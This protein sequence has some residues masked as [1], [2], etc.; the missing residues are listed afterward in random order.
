MQTLVI[1]ATKHEIEL[2]SAENKTADILITGV[3]VPATCYELLK[4]LSSKQYGLVIQAGIAGSF[5]TGIELGESVVVGQD[6]FADIG[7]EEKEHFMPICKSGFTDPNEFP[8]SGGWLVNQNPLL[9]TCGLPVVKGVTV[10]KVSDST[11]QYRQLTGNFAPGVETMEG[12]ALHY[13]CL[14]E[15]ISY[16]QVRSLSNYVGDRDKNNWKMKLSIQNL[17]ETLFRFTHDA[18]SLRKDEGSTN[19]NP[20][21]P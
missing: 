10:N 16:L 9:D 6:I 8:Y 7:M 19:I 20:Y 3:G 11:L 5:N 21:T 15:G 17:N 12:A 14:R 18:G 1:A 13:T 2:F 4:R